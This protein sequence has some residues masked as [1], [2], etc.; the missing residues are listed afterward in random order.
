MTRT[1][2][3]FA[4]FVPL[5][6]IALGLAAC[7]EAPENVAT[8]APPP[9]TLVVAG[10]GFVMAKPDQATVSVGVITE[11]DSAS[12]AL[13]ENTTRMTALIQKVGELGI[14]ETD[15]QTS[16]L[17]VYPRY[18]APDPAKPGTI[19]AIT[20]YT[21][22]NMVTVTLHDLQKVGTAL[23]KFVTMAGANN[24]NGLSF[25]FA[26]ST[27]LQDDAR[28]KAVADAARKAAL[29]ASAA[30]VKLGALQS[31]TE[32]SVGFPMPYQAMMGRA[33]EMTAVPI[34]P[35]ENKVSASVRLTYAI[36]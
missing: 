35:G 21:V 2:R 26:E 13:A 15:V 5:A 34:A 33:R 8:A 11:G 30:G 24:V 3:A 9:R 18:A 22:S 14:P 29:Y 36:D 12:L 17:S 16:D 32:E 1:A 25:G 19:P 6:L 20:G 31:I 23:D 27:S 28:K 7:N 10:E 4:P